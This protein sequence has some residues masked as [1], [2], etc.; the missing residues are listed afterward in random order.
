M[1]NLLLCVKVGNGNLERW[2]HLSVTNEQITCEY[3]SHI[4]DH[5][6]T[7][8]TWKPNATEAKV[9]QAQ[10]LWGKD[11]YAEMSLEEFLTRMFN[12]LV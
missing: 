4:A 10:D 6:R 2:A 8:N 11:K 12:E 9:Y 5:G 7:C 1:A 3:V